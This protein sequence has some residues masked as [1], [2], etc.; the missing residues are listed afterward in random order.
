[1]ETLNEL[2]VCSSVKISHSAQALSTGDKELGH[3]TVCS[4]ATS[5]PH[6][7]GQLIGCNFFFQ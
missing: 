7:Q 4:R 3:F 2:L 6:F 5:F 1:M